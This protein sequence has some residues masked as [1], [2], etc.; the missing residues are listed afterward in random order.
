MWPFD[1]VE[2]AGGKPSIE[3]TCNGEHAHFSPEEVSALLLSKM[4]RIAET[5]LGQAIANAV[6]TVPAHFN[7]SQRLATRD[8]GL[9]AGFNVLRI[10]N[11]TSAAAV[12]FQFQRISHAQYLPVRNSVRN[13]LIVDIGGGSL[14]AT[15]FQIED[16]ILEVKATAGDPIFGGEDLDTTVLRFALL[17]IQANYGVDLSLDRSALMRLRGNS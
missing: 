13:V 14:D 4:K 5:H 8:A 9:L 12:A 7:E 16:N 15:I 2:D 10:M 1:I 11:E 17:E 3:V 6:I